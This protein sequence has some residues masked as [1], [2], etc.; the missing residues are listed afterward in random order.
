MAAKKDDKGA[1]EQ[2][3]EAGRQAQGAAETA[4]GAGG[5]LAQEGLGQASELARRQAEQFRAL[6]GAGTRLYGDLGDVSRGDV[7]T[8]ME[9]GARLAKGVQD[10]GWE[11]M[12]YTQQSFQL[13]LRTANDLMSCRTVEDMVNV[14][15]NFMRQSVDTFLQESAKLLEIS[16]GV[17]DEASKAAQPRQHRTQ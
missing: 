5:R 11:V 13:S 17:A 15:R 3:G 12:S 7:D 1:A 14:Q 16:G 8:L 10:M 2:M 9:T 6:M 4:V